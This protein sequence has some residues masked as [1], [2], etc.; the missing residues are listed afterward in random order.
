MATNPII[1]FGLIAGV[2]ASIL[3][4]SRSRNLKGSVRAFILIF[5]ASGTPFHFVLVGL[6]FGS[7]VNNQVYRRWSHNWGTFLLSLIGVVP[8]FVVWQGVMR[9]L[10]VLLVSGVDDAGGVIVLGIG[11]AYILVLLMLLGLCIYVLSSFYVSFRRRGTTSS[12]VR[13]V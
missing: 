7:W 11:V 13:C 2:I 6:Y 9:L 10:I 8:L 4:Y 5:L 3:V 12:Q 1:A